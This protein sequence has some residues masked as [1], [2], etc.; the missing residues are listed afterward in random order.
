MQIKG[1][2]FSSFFEPVGLPKCGFIHLQIISDGSIFDYGQLF[3]HKTFVMPYAPTPICC[4]LET[5]TAGRTN[6]V[7]NNINPKQYHTFNNCSEEKSSPNKTS[8]LAHLEAI[9]L[10]D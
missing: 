8:F 4:H 7:K 10:T 9:V 6:R 1:A 5:N 3:H 2:S